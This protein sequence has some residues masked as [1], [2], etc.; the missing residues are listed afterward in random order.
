ME[1]LRRTLHIGR[2]IVMGHSFGGYLAQA[3]A[4]RY[5][6]SVRALILISSSAPDLK[7]EGQVQQQMAAQLSPRDRAKIASLG[8]LY[9]RNPDAAM[10]QQMDTLL[11][12]FMADRR[13]W[14]KIKPLMDPPH[15]SYAMS[16]AL[17]ADLASHYEAG[18]LHMLH[19]PVLAIY[20]EKDGGVDLFSQAIRA[21]TN[22]ARIAVVAGAGHFI[23]L[24]QPEVYRATINR[25]LRMVPRV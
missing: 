25:F 20:G 13:N 24:E 4:S 12:Y 14:P 17:Y 7:L 22:G 10:Q 9:R 19:V 6:G 23:W 2:W 3:Y 5:S 21:N 1:T 8:G 11:P 15:N 16:R 18:S